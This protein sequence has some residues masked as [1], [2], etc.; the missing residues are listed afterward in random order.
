MS[1]VRDMAPTTKRRRRL[2]TIAAASAL[3]L[4]FAIPAFA[5]NG[6]TPNAKASDNAVGS[7]FG[8]ARAAY[9]QRV[10]NPGETFS[11]R[12]G[13]NAVRNEQFKD[14]CKAANHKK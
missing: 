2:R 4:A 9:V 1:R 8:E 12:K 11:A 7:C 13:S 14:K 6:G 10:E 3:S 5:D